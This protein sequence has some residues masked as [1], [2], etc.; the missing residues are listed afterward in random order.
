[1]A[2][3]WTEAFAP[4]V[5]EP[6]ERQLRAA[7][8][9]ERARLDADLA[10]G[11]PLDRPQVWLLDDVPVWAREKRTK[12]RDGGFFLLVIAEVRWGAGPGGVLEART[13]LRLVRAM[14]K[15]SNLAWRLCFDELGYLPDFVVADAGTGILSAINAH[16]AAP[17][18][19]FVPSLWHLRRSIRRSLKL[20]S[21]K[22][23]NPDIEAHLDE[24]AREGAALTSPDAWRGW[25]D[26]LEVLVRQYGLPVDKAAGQRHNYE[27]P[28]VAVLPDLLANPGV[29]VS[30][31]G[32]ETIL[33][34]AV[35][36][37]LTQRSQLGNI[38]RTNA[39]FDLAVAR[40]HHA[41]DDLGE[42]A[43]LLR[44]DAEAHEGWTVALRAYD[45]SQPPIGRYSSLRD[46]TLLSSLARQRG[47][48]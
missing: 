45:D 22:A 35:E 17:R 8:L 15:S 42:V 13:E 25:W 26:A 27:P 29:P 3:G 16:F 48:A 38:E 14:A 5:W 9:A 40:A 10:V 31:G 2:A 23:Y 12:R 47:L 6:V 11:R 32:L 36:P 44:D 18:T 41:F 20:E 46:V 28:M 4:V 21:Q 30:T 34:E 24:L 39:L 37:V 7:A 33:R 19:R 1:V 43:R